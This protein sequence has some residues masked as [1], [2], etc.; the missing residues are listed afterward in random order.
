MSDRDLASY[1]NRGIAIEAFGN[2][3]DFQDKKHGNL[4]VAPHTIGEWI[5]LIEAELQ[6]A[7][8]ACIKGGKGRNSV[9]SEIIQVGA[10]A[11][12]CIEQHGTGEIEKRS[13]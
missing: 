3:R 6:E 4:K 12:A 7:K 1:T 11:M 9:L 8:E 13:V 2:E 10:L 5:L